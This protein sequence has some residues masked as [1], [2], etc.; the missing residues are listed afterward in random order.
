MNQPEGSEDA[1]T[2]AYYEA[3]AASYGR[4]T[5]AANLDELYASFLPRLRPGSRILDVGCGAGRDLR[6]FRDRGY[7]AVGVDPS[8]AL[9]QLAREHSGCE[10]LVQ[11]VE[12]TNFRGEF[13]GVWACASLL[14]LPRSA[15]PLA[16]RSIRQALRPHG[17]F[18]LSMQR[19]SGETRM[20]DGRFF[21]R[22]QLSDLR[23]ELQV[24]G[25]EILDGWESG[26]SL[27]AGRPIR[28]INLLARSRTDHL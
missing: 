22:Y 15:L 6:A 25:F 24:A 8:P 7:G 2:I 19:G 18:F 21:A 17:A 12:A 14:H 9:A 20:A 16:L 5:Q 26:D 3:N 4:Q 28:W 13:D 1:R 11:P 27:G 10:V 23:G